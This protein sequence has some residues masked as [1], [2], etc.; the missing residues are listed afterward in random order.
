M[1]QRFPRLFWQIAIPL[2]LLA[3]LSIWFRCTDADISL[4]RGL[5]AATGITNWQDAELGVW[6]FIK[7]YGV[8][9]GFI[10]TLAAIVVIFAGLMSP[11]LAHWI[12]PGVYIVLVTAVGSGLISNMILKDHWGR[13]RP[14][15]VI[16]LGGDDAFVKVLTPAFELGGKSF[17]CGHATVG[18]LFFAVALVLR[19]SR[20]RLSWI[21]MALALILGGLLGAA[22]M[23]QGGHFPSDVLWAAGI[24]WFTSVGLLHALRLQDFNETP[25]AVAPKN[26]RR[27]RFI[28]TALAG[29][30]VLL[31]AAALVSVPQSRR[32]KISIPAPS[33]GTRQT[34]NFDFKGTLRVLSGDASLLQVDFDGCGTPKSKPGLSMGLSWGEG[35]EAIKVVENSH[36]FF[37]EKNFTATL[38]LAPGEYEIQCGDGVK[39]IIPPE[40]GTSGKTGGQFWRLKI[41]GTSQNSTEAPRSR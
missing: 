12:R 5:R 15:H 34:F 30:L 24:M 22:R 17:P 37:T 33:S 39:P 40:L 38:T 21:A 18:F 13:P 19:N 31:V 35:Q 27:T 26:P 32:Q 4:I 23:L 36:G 20:P 11:R 28:A 8:I 9:P 14:K 2:L 6:G 3:G 16:E 25:L 10:V 7:A 1:T 29:A 41:P